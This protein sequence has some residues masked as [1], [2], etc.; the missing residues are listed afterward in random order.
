VADTIAFG[1]SQDPGVT[2]GIYL[3]PLVGGD[4][5]LAYASSPGAY[6]FQPTW[7]PD[8]SAIAFIESYGTSWA[9]RALNRVTGSVTTLVAADVL[10][11]PKFPEWNRGGDRIALQATRMVRVKGRTVERTSIYLVGVGRDADGNY[12]AQGL[13][14]LLADG[15]RPSWSPNGAKVVVDG[16]QVIEVST[17]QGQSLPT[18][19][20]PDWRR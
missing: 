13:P 5:V 18:G 6:P 11:Y 12:A 3:V 7:S 14:E 15:S 10:Q 2:N 17:G 8:G 19:S 20:F 16:L 1:G 9:L 4:P